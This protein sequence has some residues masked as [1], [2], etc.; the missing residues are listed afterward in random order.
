MFFYGLDDLPELCQ[1]IGFFFFP[2][3]FIPYL[4]VG[5]SPRDDNILTNA[6]I[7]SEWNRQS[8]SALTV[9][10]QTKSSGEKRSI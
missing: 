4:K 7:I 3:L 5:I 9:K 2:Q 6:G 10:V 1:T 8:N